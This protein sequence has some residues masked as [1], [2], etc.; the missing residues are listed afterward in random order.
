MLSDSVAFTMLSPARELRRPQTNKRAKLLTNERKGGGGSINSFNGD[1][2]R[3]R[4]RFIGGM[5]RDDWI[6]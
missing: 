3:R 1:V 6:S 4:A 2:Q 5:M